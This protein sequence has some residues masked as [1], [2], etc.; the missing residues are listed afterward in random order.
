M[1]HGFV[2]SR[3]PNRNPIKGWKECVHQGRAGFLFAVNGFANG[4]ELVCD[5]DRRRIVKCSGF[6][7]VFH[8]FGLLR[9]RFTL[10]G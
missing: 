10:R 9:R 2:F 4:V 3:H 7:R 6:R 5:V 1:P 8:W